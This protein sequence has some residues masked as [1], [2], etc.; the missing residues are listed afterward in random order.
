MNSMQIILVQEEISNPSRNRQGLGASVHLSKGRGGEPFGSGAEL[1][2]K[3]A[4][5]PSAPEEN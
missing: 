1:H 3:I 4:P 2:F 5:G